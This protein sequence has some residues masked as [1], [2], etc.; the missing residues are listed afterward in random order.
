MVRGRGSSLSRNVASIDGGALY[1]REGRVDL[2]VRCVVLCDAGVIPV[3][4]NHTP[5][6]GGHPYNGVVKGVRV[7]GR[8]SRDG[9]GTLLGKRHCN[10]RGW[11]VHMCAPHA[12]D[13]NKCNGAASPQVLDGAIVAGN[14]AQ[15]DGGAVCARKGSEVQL[16]I[17]NGSA[18]TRNTAT[19]GDG[20]AV[21]AGVLLSNASLSSNVSLTFNSA[22]GSGG[23]LCSK[24]GIGTVVVSSGSVVAGN[25]A[26]GQ[27]GAI[28]AAASVANVTLSESG[29]VVGNRAT[30]GGALAVPSG[31]LG[32]LLLRGSQLSGNRAL[33][34][35]GGVFAASVGQVVVANGSSMSDN[36]ADSGTGG[37]ISATGT[38]DQLT[39]DGSPGSGARPQGGG[40]L[41]SLL[42]P[43]TPILRR[44][45]GTSIVACM[46][47]WN[48]C[49]P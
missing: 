18:V 1:S 10:T 7:D 34:H 26:R 17:A 21:F 32:I 9:Q 49:R 44:P 8:R 5:A 33:V 41:A 22:G 47:S 30:N 45:S 3:S 48:F 12:R 31:R 13:A 28:Y 38:I 20:G 27:G 40:S 36:A 43:T 19:Q 6:V 14:F 24:G 39:M 11:H 29:A 25:T 2:Q 46:V 23:A 35:G 42:A 4:F 37:A 15:R 16:I